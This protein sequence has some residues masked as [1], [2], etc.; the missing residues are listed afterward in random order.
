MARI[1]VGI[2]TRNRPA[3]VMQ[4][5]ESV[6]AQSCGDF[7]VV[8]SDNASNEEAAASVRERIGALGDPR[9]SFHAQPAN[10]G[11]YGQGRYLFRRAAGHEFFVILHDDDVL[12]PGYFARALEALAREPQL[13]YFTANPGIIDANGEPDRAETRRYLAR[14]G[15]VGRADGVIDVLHA[16]LFHDFTPISGTF[17]RLAALQDSGFVDD[18]C[19]G[20]YPFEPNVF[21]RLGD[22]GAKAWFCAEELV[23]VRFHDQALR[24]TYDL[25]G[26]LQMVDTWILLMERRLYHGAIERRRKLFLGRL[27]R[28]R[29]LCL[30]KS[31]DIA[32]SRAALMRALRASPSLRTIA[33]APFVLAMPGVTRKFLP[34]PSRQFSDEEMAQFR[35]AGAGDAPEAARA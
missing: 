11:E 26:N 21:L 2:P 18:G 28:A 8:V 1:F 27:H 5:L 32:G 30:L 17:F 33:A 35:R 24:S 19:V 25:L 13:A 4:A 34:A 16:L 23:G 15:R 3:F 7:S 10:G 14:H 6:L 22:R 29:M 20:L 9:V 12:R 31:G